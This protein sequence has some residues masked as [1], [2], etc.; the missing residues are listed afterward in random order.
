MSKGSFSQHLID[1]HGAAWF[2]EE[3][4]DCM[5]IQPGGG[6][7]KGS[8]VF[9]DRL[10]AAARQWLASGEPLTYRRFMEL[11]LLAQLIAGGPKVFRPA[12]DQCLALEQIAPRI[13][14]ADFV[15]PYPVMVIDLPD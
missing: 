11:W 13:P 14:V 8:V 1:L 12:F 7:G 15:L 2:Y 10:S 6:D 9:E 4:A 3:L 5:T